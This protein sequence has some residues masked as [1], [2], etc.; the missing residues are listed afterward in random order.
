MNSEVIWLIIG[1][2][3]VITIIIIIK[4]IIKHMEKKKVDEIVNFIDQKSK[5]KQI[6]NRLQEC[7]DIMNNEIERRKHK[8]GK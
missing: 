8:N 7:S 3:I 6:V 1:E 2:I 4:I 5:D